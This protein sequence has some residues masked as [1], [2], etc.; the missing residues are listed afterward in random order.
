M[1]LQTRS[2]GTINVIARGEEPVAVARRIAPYV[3]QMHCKDTKVVFTPRGVTRSGRPC[4]EGV[5]DFKEIFKILGQYHT[6]IHAQ[7]EDGAAGN[8]E[9]LYNDYQFEESGACI[10]DPKWIADN[11]DIDLNEVAQLVRYAQEYAEAVQAG[12]EISAEEYE[13]IPYSVGRYEKLSRSLQHLRACIDVPDEL[14]HQA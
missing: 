5:V 2:F 4:G 8:M 12:K 6:D 14:F 1:S 3:R 11:P 10:Y 9:Q 7:I 13:S